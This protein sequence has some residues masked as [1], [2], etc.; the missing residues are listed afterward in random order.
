[1]LMYGNRHIIMKN[2]LDS[3]QVDSLTLERYWL[4]D[5]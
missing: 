5:G 1:M 3:M 2:G 4:W